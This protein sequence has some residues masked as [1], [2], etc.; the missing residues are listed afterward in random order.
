MIYELN[1]KIISKKPHACG[2]NEWQIVRLGADVKLKCLK[3][4]RSLF[5]SVDQLNKMIK[6]YFPL[7]EKDV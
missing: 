7:K 2:G 4:E 6:Q 3:C 5:L 1:S